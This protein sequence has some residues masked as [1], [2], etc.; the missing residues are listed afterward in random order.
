M[1]I[2]SLIAVEFAA[3]I[4]IGVDNYAIVAETNLISND[5]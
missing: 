3:G 1:L 2:C 4:Q 5:V